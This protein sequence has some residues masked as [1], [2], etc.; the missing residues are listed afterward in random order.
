MKLL[1]YMPALN[2]E[3]HIQEVI[4]GLPRTLDKIDKIQFLVVDDGST[5][6][7]KEI[8]LAAGAQV[9]SHKRNLGV[10]AAFHS[11][12]Q[13]ALENDADILVG[14]DADG[15]FDPTDILDLILP[16]LKNSADIVVGNRFVSGLPKHMSPVKYLGN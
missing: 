8:S 7:T 2:E 11:A 16:I 5:D 10:G 13:F 3:K 14:I 1:I 12:V 4:S 15:Q 9:I 6:K